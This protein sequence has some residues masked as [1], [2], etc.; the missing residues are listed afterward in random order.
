[1]RVVVAVKGEVLLS[2]VGIDPCFGPI[3]AAI[4]HPSEILIRRDPKRGATHLACQRAGNPEAVKR[5]DAATLGVD[6]EDVGIFPMLGHGEDTDGIAFKKEFRSQSHGWTDTR[7][8][9]IWVIS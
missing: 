6:P 2:D 8:S 5:D 1:M 4:D 3:R 7:S 9:P